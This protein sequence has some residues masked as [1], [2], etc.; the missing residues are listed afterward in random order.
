M[1]AMVR[2][3]NV[4]MREGMALVPVGPADA[5]ALQRMRQGQHVW[6]SLWLERN[7]AALRRWRALLSETAPHTR[8]ENPDNLA[9]IMKLMTGYSQ[10]IELPGPRIAFIERSTSPA[11]MDQIEFSEFM[12]SAEEFVATHILKGADVQAL[13]REMQAYLAGE[14]RARFLG[15]FR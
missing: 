4:F 10:A 1:S 12:T 11:E 3:G 9:S 7:P 6:V 5:A 2:Q 14:A 15:R 8:F 13:R